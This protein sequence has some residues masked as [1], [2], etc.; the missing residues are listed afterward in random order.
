[1]GSVPLKRRLILGE[2]EGRM[3][4][5]RAKPTCLAPLLRA[6]PARGARSL[7][8]VTPGLCQAGQMPAH[9]RGNQAGHRHGRQH[10][11]HTLS[12]LMSHSQRETH[13][14][15]QTLQACK[16]IARHRNRLLAPSPNPCQTDSPRKPPLT[17]R[18]PGRPQP[19]TQ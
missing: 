10:M 13:P 9:T 16:T 6:L 15:P 18:H 3:S 11:P 2:M 8:T 7:T 12:T 1:M 14:P 19:H 17:I 4:E 5:G